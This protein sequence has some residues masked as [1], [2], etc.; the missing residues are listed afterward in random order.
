VVY[1]LESDFGWFNLGGMR[2]VSASYPVT[3]PASAGRSNNIYTVGTSFQSNS[4]VT[5]RGRLGFTETSVLPYLTGGL[6]LT[7]FWMPSSFADNVGAL[8]AF[9]S[10][11]NSDQ[12]TGWTVGGGLEWAVNDH[13]SIKGEYLF[14]NLGR[15]ATSIAP[16][17][18]GN[19]SG[20]GVTSDL[21]LHVARAGVN[22]KF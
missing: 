11:G 15:I 7:G 16:G 13:W 8:G 4:L 10:A 9:G 20:L 22:F 14:V 5:L 21:N 2:Q 6:A 1:G 3:A 17:F 18:A 19:P 12:R